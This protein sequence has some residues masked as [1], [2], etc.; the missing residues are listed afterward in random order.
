VAFG[1]QETWPGQTKVTGNTVYMVSVWCK[2]ASGPTK[3]SLTVAWKDASTATIR[4]DTI[5]SVTG[6]VNGWQQIS[7]S[8]TSP[9]GSVTAYISITGTSAKAGDVHF[10]DDLSLSTGA[11]NA[12]LPSTPPV[13]LPPVAQPIPT[14][15][16]V[17][18]PPPAGAICTNPVWSSTGKGDGH[19]FASYYLHNN[20]WYT[21]AAPLGPQTTSGCNFNSWFV[22][23]NQQDSAS[24]RGAVKS[25]PNI[26]MDLTNAFTTGVP[27]SN[28]GTLSTTWQYTAPGS[29][30]YDVAYDIWLNGVGWGNGH[31]EYMIWTE[32]VNHRPL[33][34][35][36][37]STT[38]NNILWD[39]WWYVSIYICVCD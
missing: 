31:T 21:G 36:R 30:I 38:I 6:A 11:A 33:G 32:N 12:P 4:S 3:V 7:N 20:V 27:F 2:L 1:V 18:P 34:T 25:Y 8:V 16:P 5:G 23:S 35:L 10:V 28:F 14:V 17:I 13:T 39:M 29:G 37:L 24:D 26:H 15:P 19:T 22:V 9:A